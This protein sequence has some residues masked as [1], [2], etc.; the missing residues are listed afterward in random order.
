[1]RGLSQRLM[2]EYYATRFDTVEVNNSFY[3]LPA[4]GL[5]AGWQARV[6][7][8][9]VFA[10]KAS[11]YLTHMKKLTSPEAPLEVL[12]QR[13]QELQPKL[14]AILYQLPPQLHKDL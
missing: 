1:P 6:P 10:V 12:F 2:L 8:Q 5:M 7:A 9:F 11:R 14:G 13:T 3:K 4:A